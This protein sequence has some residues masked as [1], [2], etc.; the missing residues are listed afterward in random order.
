MQT[1]DPTQPQQSPRFTNPKM[2]VQVLLLGF[3][4][5]FVT[6]LAFELFI[7][8][9]RPDMTPEGA[10]LM[11]SLSGAVSAGAPIT[12][13]TLPTSIAG[14]E[15]SGPQIETHAPSK[16]HHN[17][18]IVHQ[19]SSF[20]IRDG[21]GYQVHEYE[22]PN[23]LYQIAWEVLNPEE[24]KQIFHDCYASAKEQ[25]EFYASQGMIRC[26]DVWTQPGIGVTYKQHNSD[27]GQMWQISQILF[28]EACTS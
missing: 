14:A 15:E 28:Y 1:I 20:R 11:N 26:T 17:S 23:Q 19:C 9:D 22:A 25:Y 6:Y 24:R 5:L 21:E 13:P 7:W 2:I 18:Q 3:A 12:L 27:W 16:T 8:E 4:L 10:R